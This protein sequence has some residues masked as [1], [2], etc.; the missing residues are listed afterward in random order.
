MVRQFTEMFLV[1]LHCRSGYI[2]GFYTSYLSNTRLLQVN[3]GEDAEFLI[4]KAMKTKVTLLVKTL[5]NTWP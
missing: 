4:P 3:Q 1:L 2:V 5:K